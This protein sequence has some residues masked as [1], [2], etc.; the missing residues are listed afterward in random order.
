MEETN[1]INL[2]TEK[3]ADLYNLVAQ[4]GAAFASRFSRRL[5]SG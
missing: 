4:Y 5:P 1:L 3:V 2:G